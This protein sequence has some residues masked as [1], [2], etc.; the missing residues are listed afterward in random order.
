MKRFN[1]TLKNKIRLYLTSIWEVFRDFVYSP[2][3]FIFSLLIV[4][5][6]IAGYH[7]DKAIRLQDQL[8]IQQSHTERWKMEADRNLNA[9]QECAI[10]NKNNKAKLEE[11]KSILWFND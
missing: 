11:I 2:Y 7:R 1:P 10:D 5:S 8:T 4:M 6:G 9:L 3:F